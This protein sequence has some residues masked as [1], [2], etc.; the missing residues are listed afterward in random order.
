M[1][2]QGY[3]DIYSFSAGG[4]YGTET[5]EELTQDA[6]VTQRRHCR[7][8]ERFQQG[9]GTVME[10]GRGQEEANRCRPPAR[11][12]GIGLV[13][14]MLVASA[15]SV[16]TNTQL[17]GHTRLVLAAYVG[18]RKVNC[19]RKIPLYKET[20]QYVRRVLS[21]IGSIERRS[22]YLSLRRNLRNDLS[23]KAPNNSWQEIGKGRRDVVRV[24][25]NS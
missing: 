25:R 5:A 22:G 24:G 19:Y 10:S 1:Q 8:S 6:V 17:H 9:G 16:P 11:Q 18:E 14:L 4:P 23:S 2:V 13:C 15:P 12:I 7:I 3:I 20:R 21:T